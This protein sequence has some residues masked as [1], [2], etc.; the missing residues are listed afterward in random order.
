MNKTEINKELKLSS[1]KNKLLITLKYNLLNIYKIDLSHFERILYLLQNKYPE[2]E[3]LNFIENG[4]K[5][6]IKYLSNIKY[7]EDLNNILREISSHLKNYKNNN[8]LEDL[9]NNIDSGINYQ[10]TNCNEPLMSG[11]IENINITTSIGNEINCLRE[12]I[13][14]NYKN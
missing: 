7:T 5:N 2:V 4:I 11:I 13:R 14:D 8:L 10:L 12:D 9:L 3:D 1:L 6:N